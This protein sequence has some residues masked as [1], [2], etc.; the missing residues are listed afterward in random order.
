M[1]GLTVL[2]LQSKLALGGTRQDLCSSEDSDTGMLTPCRGLIVAAI[3]VEWQSCKPKYYSAQHWYSLL[4][5]SL[6]HINAA[7]VSGIETILLPQGTQAIATAPA[8]TPHTCQSP[9]LNA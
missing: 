2:G 4:H 1:N 9:E 6:K 8:S 7:I 5:I 3:A